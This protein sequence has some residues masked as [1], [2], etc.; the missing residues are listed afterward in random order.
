MDEKSP[1]YIIFDP[2]KFRNAVS[3]TTEANIPQ[4]DCRL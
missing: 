4:P 2:E 3:A 1:F